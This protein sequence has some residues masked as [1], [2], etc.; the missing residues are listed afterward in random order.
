[1]DSYEEGGVEG[2]ES[3]GQ[4]TQ[5]VGRWHFFLTLAEKKV[6]DNLIY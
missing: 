6:N 3:A 5:T 4:L 2:H 1:V